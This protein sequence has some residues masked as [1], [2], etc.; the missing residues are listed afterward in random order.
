MVLGTMKFLSAFSKSTKLIWVFVLFLNCFKISDLYAQNTFGCG[1]IKEDLGKIPWMNEVKNLVRKTALPASVDLSGLMPPVKTQGRQNSCVAWAFGYYYKTYQEWQ[2][3]GWDVNAEIHQFSPAFIY[4]HINGG[5][6]NGA[7]FSDALNIL[8]N[9]GCATLA[10][11]QY[12]DAN[13]TAWAPEAAYTHA[14]NF[15]CEKAYYINLKNQAAIDEV[16]ARLSQGNISVLGIYIYD[17]FRNIQMYNNNYCV[18][19]LTGSN[20]VGHAVTIVGYDDNRSTNDGS[21]AFKCVNSWGTGWGD[22]GYFWISYDAII[23]PTPSQLYA[24]FTTDLNNYSP[25]ILIK[26]RLTH[27]LR[28]SVVISVSFNK[29]GFGFKPKTFFGYG[30][31]KGK[32][33]HAFPNNNIVLDYSEI[34]DYIDSLKE[35]GIFIQCID[36]NKENVS[37]SL[38]YF[39]VIHNRWK[40]EF[41]STEIPKNILNNGKIIKAEVRIAPL[42]FI[43]DQSADD[44]RPEKLNLMQNYPNPFNSS[45]VFCFELPF[46]NFVTLRIYDLWGKEIKTLINKTL[47]SGRYS[48]NFIADELPA[49]IYFYKLNAGSY[50]SVKKMIYLK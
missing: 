38:D 32:D 41:I 22:N 25:S 47:N 23:H 6:D 13:C 44:K 4:N 8:I 30:Q 19:D 33:S 1:L 35:N 39:S 37:G 36:T 18:K 28:G 24:I 20:G 9:H 12:S 17:N 26:T 3:H 42:L 2:E 31:K 50:S 10:D 11:M 34:N 16:K 45:T 5:I 21:G 7:Y 15:K 46:P 48:I 43:H 27:S 14:I 49:G 29:F 40:K